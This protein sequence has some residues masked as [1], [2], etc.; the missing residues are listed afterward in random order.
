MICRDKERDGVKDL[1]DSKR[2]RVG[3]VEAEE[4][5]IEESDGEESD[6]EDDVEEDKQITEVLV[7]ANDV[8]ELSFDGVHAAPTYTHQLF[9]DEMIVFP[10]AR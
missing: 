10:G 7:R 5:D 1:Q 8:I 3:A 4:E 9:D 2:A 6:E